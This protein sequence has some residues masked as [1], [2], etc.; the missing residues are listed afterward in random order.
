MVKM[1]SRFAQAFTNEQKDP[2]FDLADY[3]GQRSSTFRF[4]LLNS[5]TGEHLGQVHPL[6]DTV[7]TLEHDTT[8]TIK[9]TL[10]MDFGRED[11]ARINTITDR[12]LPYMVFD[13]GFEYPLGRYMFSDVTRQKFTSGKLSSTSLVDESFIIDQPM[14]QSFNAGISAS[15]EFLDTTIDLGQPISQVLFKLLESID[16]PK[17]FEDNNA[18]VI[19]SWALG[20]SR[21]KVFE[22]VA[23]QAGFFSP[24]IDN[25]GILRLIIAFD[26]ADREID[27]D[28]DLS[29]TIKYSTVAESD[30]LLI[31]PNRIIVVNNESNNAV[32]VGTYDIPSSAPHSIINR[33]FVIPEVR[34]IQVSSGSGANTVAR[35][36][37][38]RET[39][40]E[41]VTLTTV[42][43]PR[44][45]SYNVIKWDNEKWLEL[46]WSMQLAE[47]GDMVHTMRKAY[48][49]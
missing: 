26:P 23:L 11:T 49:S 38:I 24:W 37:G 14:E 4:D 46:S 6:R 35:N 44:F 30:D 36:I 28:L 10:T 8:R 3:I 33:G 13:D 45:D 32:I 48:G 15:S 21:M 25:T 19:G 29:N 22:D 47:G 18:N 2:K 17:Q 39:V 27:F 7:P 40:F 9:R 12:I 31:A 42:P 20:T 41:R 34:N 5:V 16:I 1:A 43:D